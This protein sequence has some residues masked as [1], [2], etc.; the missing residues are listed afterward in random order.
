MWDY[1]DD[2]DDDDDDE[3]DDGEE[4]CGKDVYDIKFM[5]MLIM[6]KISVK[7]ETVTYE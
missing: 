3:D 7:M 1:D 5:L 6:S 4:D 2:D